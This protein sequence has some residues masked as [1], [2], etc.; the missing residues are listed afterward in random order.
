MRRG[1]QHHFEFT[2]AVFSVAV[3]PDRN[4][5]LIVK[6]CMHVIVYAID[7]IVDMAIICTLVDSWA[8][9]GSN[10]KAWLNDGQSQDNMNLLTYHSAIEFRRL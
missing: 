5:T 7:T 8:E 3:S 6:M 1:R 10:Y 4:Y 2:S 9:I